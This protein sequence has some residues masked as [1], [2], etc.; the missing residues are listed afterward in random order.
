[1]YFNIASIQTEYFVR[2][3]SHSAFAGAEGILILPKLP[4]YREKPKF[5]ERLLIYAK[6][7]GTYCWVV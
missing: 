1:V 3:S 7:R 2:H 5:L 4:S 6:T